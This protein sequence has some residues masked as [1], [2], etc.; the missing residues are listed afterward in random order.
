MN[1]AL[2]NFAIHGDNIVECERTLHFIERAL[3][4]ETSALRGPFG[5]PS[6][7]SFEF[8]FEGG[9]TTLRFVFFPGF[10][11]WNTD[12]RKA[13]WDRGGVIRES[14]DVIVSEVTTGYELPLLAIE[15]SGALAAGNQAW[16]RSGRAYSLGLARIPYLYVAELGGYEL[17]TARIRKAPRLPNP[18]V[19]FSYLS[20][21]SSTETPVISAFIPNPGIDEDTRDLFAPVLGGDDIL[22]FI[23]VVIVNQDTRSIT[24]VLQERALTF[25]QGLATR[26]RT[27]RTLTPQQWTS[28]Y[29]SIQTPS[30]N[31]L[32]TYLLDET[33][34]RWSKKSS[35]KSLTPT[36]REL[37]AVAA[38]LSIGL[39]SADLPMCLVSQANR[40]A[41]ARH[42]ARLHPGI[43]EAFLNW[44]RRD[45][46]LVVCWV[47]GFKPGGDDAR[48]DRG[49]PPFARM[50][51][52][53]H[54]DILTI[55]Y[56]PVP[57]AHWTLFSQ[58]LREL[59]KRNGLWEA[60][61]A[62]SDAILIDSPIG[63]LTAHGLKRP[64]LGRAST[65]VTPE[66]V[67]VSSPP[68]RIGE[69][70]VDTVI[71]TVCARLGAPQ[72][73]EGLCNPPGGDW[74]GI[75]LLTASR[76]KELRWL[77]LP[78]ISGSASKR[79]D[80]VLQIFGIGEPP[81][82]LA[83]ESK[84]SQKA[85]EPQ[86]GPRLRAYMLTLLRSSASIERPITSGAVWTY[87]DRS[88]RPRDFAFA[89]AAASL[90]RHHTDLADETERLDVDLQIGLRFSDDG[91]Q[92]DIQ[93][94]SSTAVGRRLEEFIAELPLDRIGLSTDGDQ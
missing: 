12:I 93:L 90:V 59:A 31:A 69:H 94:R 80:H 55:V 15:Y 77:S 89:T 74:S 4:I 54:A 61:M 56:G 37:M 30:K 85:V 49:L 8:D 50:L 16:Q 86:I 45:E 62:A 46:P 51:V 35:I 76:S 36:A 17:D 91:E 7:P 9:G 29:N 79:P 67:R 20:Y 75:S 28:A 5:P 72:V 24:R 38:T 39:T 92:C 22:E 41:F 33:E 63:S 82:I 32:I 13:I 48:P 11:R 26:S 65:S 27:G 47:M 3:A 42:I 40:P 70:D 83:I 43:S 57:Q 84:D 34:L 52:G 25:V 78:R 44:V 2:R 1:A 60:V 58:D 64:R 6:N 88:L 71:H 81:I 66:P 68:N 87:S 18:A 23:R 21:S 19:P 10:G 73:F 14:P 53:P